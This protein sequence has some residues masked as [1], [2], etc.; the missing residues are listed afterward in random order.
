MAVVARHQDLVD[1]LLAELES[2]KRPGDHPLD[3]DLVVRAFRFAAE[4]HDG[5]V[6]RSGQEF[7]HHPWGVAKVLAGLRTDEATV[8]AALL[9]DTVEDTGVEIDEIQA[10]FGEEIARLVEGVTKLTRVQFQSR[11]QAE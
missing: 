4:A 8:A 3:R 10:E 11:E 7:I 6:R 5:Q 9:H 2:Y 1:D